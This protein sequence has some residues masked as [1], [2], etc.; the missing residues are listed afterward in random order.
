MKLLF[1]TPFKRRASFT[2]LHIGYDSFF[3]YDFTLVVLGFSVVLKIKNKEAHEAAARM[4]KALAEL[5]DDNT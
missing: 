3:D 5:P 2:L 4:H 1:Y